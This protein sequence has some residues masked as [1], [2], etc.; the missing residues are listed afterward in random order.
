MCRS[1]YIDTTSKKNTPLSLFVTH[2]HDHFSLIDV[3]RE[4]ENQIRETPHFVEAVVSIALKVT[5]KMN[6]APQTKDYYEL[7]RINK[8]NLC[9]SFLLLYFRLF[10]LKESCIYPLVPKLHKHL[11]T[12]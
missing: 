12:L 6:L 11:Y 3:A 4:Q 5:A 2:L 7:A 1:I 10:L 8:S 9:V